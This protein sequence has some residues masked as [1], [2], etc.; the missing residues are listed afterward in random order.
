MERRAQTR[1]RVPKKLYTSQFLKSTQTRIGTGTLSSVVRISNETGVP[2]PQVALS[3]IADRPSVIAPIV[4]ARTVE[5]LRSNLG[6]A[7]LTLSK[8][9]T[10]ALEKVS[11]PQPGGYPYGLFGRWQRGRALQDG[12]GAPPSPAVGSANTLG[13]KSN[14]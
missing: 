4:G 10:E 1:G 8:D 12:I 6:A 2:P 5:H 13:K 14:G 9:A 11:R 7:E 3:W